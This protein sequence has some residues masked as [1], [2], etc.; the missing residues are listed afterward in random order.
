MTSTFSIKAKSKAAW[1]ALSALFIAVSYNAASA[2][3]LVSDVQAR[4]VANGMEVDVNFEAPYTSKGLKPEYDRNFAQIVMN[5][6]GVKSARMIP[7]NAGGVEKVFLYQYQPG[8]ARLRI[9]MNDGTE[10]P[11]GHINIWNARAGTV[12]LLVKNSSAANSAAATA[13]AGIVDRLKS[14]ATVTKVNDTERVTEGKTTA[15]E[16]VLLKSV[17]KEGGEATTPIAAKTE[18]AASEAGTLGTKSE[19][20]RH[21]ARMIT[22]LLIVLGLFLGGA[23]FL[24]GYAGRI[25]LKKLPFGKKERLIQVV[26]SHR[27]G[28]SQAISLVKITDEYM[29]MGVTGEN[30]SLIAK[31][32][33]D[34]DVEKYIEDR[35]WGGIF[36]K[37][38][39]AFTKPSSS[40]HSEVAQPTREPR[41][42]SYDG[43]KDITPMKA[44]ADTVA[45]QPRSLSSFRAAIKEKT[46][47][48]KPLA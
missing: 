12:R 22:G 16:E 6:A 26:A 37:H 13:T 45:A 11:K 34:I 46:T 23:F 1:L 9:I 47:G 35:Y 20:S 27:L 5:H 36:E 19:P 28:K 41:I 38:L 40:A 3:V 10:A 24:K 15:E 48:L 4:K 39:T 33:K 29:V 31:L 21:I 43:P 18:T 7:V 17:M 44:V 25:D 2:D 32:G 14:K 8:V 30:I 42:N